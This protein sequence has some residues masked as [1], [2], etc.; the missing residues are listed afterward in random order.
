MFGIDAGGTYLKL[1]NPKKGDLEIHP[2]PYSKEWLEMKLDTREAPFFITGSGTMKI[3]GWFPDLG[4]RFVPELQAIGLG[5]AHLAGRNECIVMNIGSGTPILYANCATKEVEHLG[6]TGMGSASLAGLSYYMTGISDLDR[7][8][9]KAYEGDPDRV[10]LL[11]SDIYE[12]PDLVSLPGDVTASNF[13]KYQDWRHL[14]NAKKPDARDLLAALHKMVGET[15]AVM[16]NLACKQHG[17]V[18]LPVSITGGGTLNHALVKYL[19]STF[20]YLDQEFIIP[21]NA[22]FSTLYG[23]FVHEGLLP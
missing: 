10:N 8:D 19:R 20:T 16:A 15:I 22:E 2:L 1:G 13:G 12:D 17:K 7:I 21:R 6:G 9:E 4:L 23:L 3:Q 18:H 5:G 14:D 11:I